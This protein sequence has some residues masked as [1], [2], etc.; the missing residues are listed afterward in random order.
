MADYIGKAQIFESNMP[1]K[2]YVC[3]GKEVAFLKEKGFKQVIENYL[4]GVEVLQ[5]T[6]EAYEEGVSDGRSLSAVKE[7]ET[8]PI[9]EPEEGK[10]DKPKGKGGRPKGSKNVTK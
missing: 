9:I 2:F 7:V 6:K 10:E 3:T 4:P 8:E 5:L 1:D